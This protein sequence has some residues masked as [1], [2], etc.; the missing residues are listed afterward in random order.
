M[1]K[2]DVILVV[3]S[4][5]V[6][7][8]AFG[9]PVLTALWRAFNGL[10]AVKEQIHDDIQDVSHRLEM[11]ESKLSGDLLKLAHNLELQETEA[12]NLSDRM[13]L[14]LNGLKEMMGHRTTRIAAEL[15]DLQARVLAAEQYLA[16]TTSFE[17]RNRG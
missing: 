8:I 3:A 10:A 1:N 7:T 14:G 12:E 9:L 6:S 4:V 13:D 16:K 15:K 5:G 17:I 2:S 11:L